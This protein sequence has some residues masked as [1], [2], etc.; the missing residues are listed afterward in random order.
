[1]DTLRGE[2]STGI[3]S[4]PTN[5]TALPE[6]FKRPV[7]AYDFIEMKKF[8]DLI[9]RSNRVLLGHNRYATMGKI[10]A[11]N[12]HPFRHGQ[13]IG[14]HNGTLTNKGLLPESQHFEVDSDN[15]MYS[16][17]QLGVQGT[18][19]KLAGAYALVW[20]DADKSTINFLRNKERTL[21]YAISKANT[22]IYW[23]SEYFMLAA[24]LNRNKVDVENIHHVEVD[25]HYA[26]EI[27]PT[28]SD[29]VVKDP[30]E[31][32][33]YVPPFQPVYYVK[34]ATYT[35]GTTTSDTKAKEETGK[36]T[37]EE[38][39]GTVARRFHLPAEFVAMGY[40]VNAEIDTIPYEYKNGRLNGVTADENGIGVMIVNISSDIADEYMDDVKDHGVFL[41][42]KKLCGFIS[43]CNDHPTGC[44]IAREQDT[45]IVDTMA[46]EEEEEADAAFLDGSVCVKDHRGNYIEEKEFRSRYS[47]CAWCSSP[48]SIKDKHFYAVSHNEA[49]CGDCS[50][51][52]NV[53]QYASSFI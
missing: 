30:V 23:A 11:A 10:I 27:Q 15:I 42:I 45:I 51:D 7:A 9:A 29:I 6:I 17:S 22:A 1:M 20:W 36:E 12:A 41:R 44:F 34:A 28:T 14:V 48:L 19:S 3:L 8:K 50:Q 31:V 43:P 46:E 52:Q 40:E 35:G 33:P 32:V 13:I 24:A 16:L 18:V 21:F 4:V 26:F 49:F 5:T 37:K 2:H 25:K 53:M 47:D 38:V 39:K